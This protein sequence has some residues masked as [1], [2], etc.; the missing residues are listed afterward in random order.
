MAPPKLQDYGYSSTSTGTD[1]RVASTAVLGISSADRHVGPAQTINPVAVPEWNVAVTYD[2]NDIVR[3]GP[4]YFISLVSAN[5]GNDPDLTLG[6]SWD[7]TDEPVGYVS[8]PGAGSPFNFTITNRGQ[9]LNGFFTRIAVSEFSFIWGI[10]T[11]TE[12]N[13]KFCLK[14]SS[15]GVGPVRTLFFTV[16][17]GFY[18]L[19][20]LA[21]AIQTLVQAN[22]NL[23]SFTITANT[24]TGEFLAQTNTATTFAFVPVN[25]ANPA[26]GLTGDMRTQYLAG[27]TQL[28]DMM[29]WRVGTGTLAT[30]TPEYTLSAVQ[31][32]GVSSLLSTKFVDVVCAKLTANQA[33]RDGSTNGQPRD[34]LCRLY[35]EANAN[36][37]DIPSELGAEPFRVYRDFAN[38]KVIGWEPS[39]PVAGLEFQLYDDQGFPLSTYSSSTTALVYNDADQPDWE[40]SLLCSEQ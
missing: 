31:R 22:I 40:C 16:P 10:P 30:P 29:A 33:S 4:D 23:S 7:I 9:L 3:Q 13:N 28:F 39:V 5:I 15:L 21:A 14:Y 37:A 19:T 32:S 24:A 18:T 20:T 26:S 12:R 8:R 38:P 25:A 35:L 17:N 1:I 27:R 2:V 11:I 6:T 34:I 36:P